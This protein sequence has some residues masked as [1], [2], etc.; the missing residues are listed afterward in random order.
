MYFTDRQAARHLEQGEL[1]RV[2]YVGKEP[3]EEVEYKDTQVRSGSVFPNTSILNG[4]TFLEANRRLSLRRA[5]TS[6][7]GS[8]VPGSASDGNKDRFIR[9]SARVALEHQPVKFWQDQVL[10]TK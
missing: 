3:T 7:E 8:R 10:N 4:D 6:A 5:E 1:F 9:Y 2:T